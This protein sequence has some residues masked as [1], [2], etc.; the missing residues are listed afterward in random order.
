MA[1]NKTTR[2]LEIDFGKDDRAIEIV[3]TQMGLAEIADV[4]EEA[5]KAA[6]PTNTQNV[7]N[8]ASQTEQSIT[9]RTIEGAETVV[10]KSA[11]VLGNL[12]GEVGELL[13]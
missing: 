4:K 9:D 3:G 7:T 1:G 12:S 13:K 2:G 11:S 6:S 10:N 8:N 5:A